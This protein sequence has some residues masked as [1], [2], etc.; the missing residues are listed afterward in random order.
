MVNLLKQ[1]EIQLL[2]V[3]NLY[4]FGLRPVSFLDKHVH[5][6]NID[7][8]ILEYFMVVNTIMQCKACLCP[9]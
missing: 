1:N 2:K 4:Y 3:N 6:Y 9:S 8:S 7:C 5:W